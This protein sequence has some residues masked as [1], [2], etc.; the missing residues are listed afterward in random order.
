MLFRFSVTLTHLLLVEVT[1]HNPR[2]PT[3]EDSLYATEATKIHHYPPYWGLLVTM[4]VGSLFNVGLSMFNTVSLSTVKHHVKG[5]QVEIPNI[6]AQITAKAA[7]A[8]RTDGTRHSFGT[9]YAQR[10][11]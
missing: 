11:P 4:A 8:Y 5:L 3:P 7:P 9:E 6:E 10:S 2:I 1:Q